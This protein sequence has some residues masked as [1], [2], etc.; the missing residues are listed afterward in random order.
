MFIYYT[1][2]TFK[3]EICNANSEIQNVINLLSKSNGLMISPGY[4]TLLHH[5]VFLVNTN[6]VFR[7][8]VECAVPCGV[9]PQ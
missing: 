7:V 4:H 1:R 5:P 6:V 9:P 3:L 8:H 2:G